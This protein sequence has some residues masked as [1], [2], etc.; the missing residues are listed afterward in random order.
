MHALSGGRA[1]RGRAARNS[2]AGSRPDAKPAPL[3]R[4]LWHPAAFT[5]LELKVWSAI[6]RAGPMGVGQA[7]E[8]VGSHRVSVGRA[9]RRLREHGLLAGDG[10]QP[11][12]TTTNA[13]GEVKY[14][15]LDPPG[16]PA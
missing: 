12:R 4:V 9:A 13:F 10:G 8:A 2:P 14:F 1:V 7:A 15:A 3:E 5:V 16:R 6:R 11:R